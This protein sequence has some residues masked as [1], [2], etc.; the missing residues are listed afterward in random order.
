MKQA[1]I[2][3]WALALAF[4]PAAVQALDFH[5]KDTGVDIGDFQIKPGLLPAIEDEG[6]EAPG[7]MATST[8]INPEDPEDA[9][10]RDEEDRSREQA[11]GFDTGL[12]GSGTGQAEAQ[13]EGPGGSKQAEN[14]IP[15]LNLDDYETEENL[16]KAIDGGEGPG[17]D[18][19][20][21]EAAATGIIEE[22]KPVLDA[23]DIRI[24]AGAS[25]DVCNLENGCS[26][27]IG[28]SHW[29]SEAYVYPGDTERDLRFFTKGNEV[30]NGILE[31]SYFSFSQKQDLSAVYSR[32]ISTGVSSFDFTLLDSGG[33]KNDWQKD[34]FKT[35][36]Q[37]EEAEI[38][39]EEKNVWQ[40]IWQGLKSFV[41][42]IRLAFKKG[43]LEIVEKKPVADLKF[44][45]CYLRVVPVLED[46]SAGQPSNEVK[47]MLAEK[48]EQEDVVIY[49]PAKLYEVRVKSFDPIRAPE[50]GVCTGAVIL[51]I[52]WNEIR[53]WGVVEH[54]AGDRICPQTYQGVGE[55]SWYESFWNF[56]KGG[57][58][59]VSEAY[60][61]LKSAVVDGLAGIAC[62]GDE[63]CKMA[64]SAGLDIGLAAMGMPP[65][66]PNFDELM[67]GGFDYLA[68]EIA[69]QAGCPD[70]V[71]RER[72][73]NE[74][75]QVLDEQKNSNPACKGEEEAH[76]MGVEPL[77][78]PD[79]VKAHTDPQ[80]TYRNAKVVLEVTRTQEDGSS[81]MGAPYKL[82]FSNI[83]YNS[84]PVGSW[85]HNI[86]PYGESVEITEPLVG[87]VF[88]GSTIILPEMEKGEKISI[89]IVLT[90]AEYWVP[91]HKEAMHGW[92]TVTYKDGWP[93]YQYDDWWK[94]YYQGE[95]TLGAAIDGCPVNY[96]D[97]DCIVSQDQMSVNLPNSLNP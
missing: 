95:L 48:Q 58:D 84:G 21:E 87:Q 7:I 57:V 90:P 6:K 97:F 96:G 44:N 52:D 2:I 14:A 24:D 26:G 39:V 50:L 80:G 15:P 35:L 92:T 5:K 88:E 65:S 66:L 40:R 63:Y 55:E 49:K 30:K 81:L 37:K 34:L 1:I 10:I 28:L 91:G 56:A 76:R 32:P 18:F 25:L 67:D 27:D 23:D 41:K 12:P 82:Y 89:P 47:L 72:I 8:V 93:Q 71:C 16:P 79:N 70:A 3:F 69:A 4:S 38:Q 78:L 86:E 83:G 20:R 62:G 31:A 43:E 45:T 59:W 22:K 13:K 51:D 17:P 68:G 64:I 73:K 42:K 74:L 75:R 11:D 85:I 33:L 29:V 46:G 36:D 54:K 61:N 53:P 77:C 19:F 9:G 60:K 94:L